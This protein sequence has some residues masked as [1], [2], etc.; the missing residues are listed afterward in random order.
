[1]LLGF[2]KWRNLRLLC[3]LDC[4]VP[5]TML[6]HCMGKIGCFLSG[7]GCYGPPADPK[8]IPWAMS[9]PNGVVPTRSPVHPTPLYEAVASLA[10]Y[11]LVVLFFPFPAPLRLG[12]EME[13]GGK[14]GLDSDSPL[15]EGE[16]RP[17]LASLRV[18][19]RSAATLVLYG[20]TRVAVEPFRRH[21][22][23]A[24]F[25]GLTEYQ[26]LAI[27]LALLG[28]AIELWSSVRFSQG[29]E[30]SHLDEE[31]VWPVKT[32]KVKGD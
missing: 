28:L 11:V 19:R 18:G 31:H 15:P 2:F 27:F 6:G 22:P 14:E 25:G 26:V 4:V 10:V 3:M 21:P 17:R 32:A 1:M 20:I 24:V 7:D 30:S 13:N 9:F 12:E 23:I 5:C 16:R 29:N 8:R